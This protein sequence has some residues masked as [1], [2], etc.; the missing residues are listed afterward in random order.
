[1]RSNARRVDPSSSRPSTRSRLGTLLLL[2]GGLALSA[3]ISPAGCARDTPCQFNSDCVQA[4]CEAGECRKDC[5][6]SETDCPKGQ[7]CNIIAKCEADDPSGTT[8]SGGSSS[9]SSSSSGGGQGGAGSTTTGTTTSSSSSSSSSTSGSGGNDPGKGSLELCNGDQECAPNLVCRSL[10]RGGTKRCTPTCAGNGS[11]PSGTHCL[12]VDG[13]SY[14]AGVDTGRTCNDPSPCN[15]GC[16]LG[17]KYCTEPCFDGSD[18]PNGYGCMPVGGTPVCVKVEAPC[19]P[20]NAS[21]CIAPA[22]C[23]TTSPT[24]AVWGCTLACNT[25]A[26]CPRRAAGL[27]PWTC[28]GLCQRP[29]DVYGPL[30]GGDPA[31]YACNENGQPT[32]LCNDAQHINF[33]AF[34]IPPVPFVDCNSPTATPGQPGDSCVDSCRYQGGCRFGFA[35]VAVGGVGQSRIGLCLP[36][37]AGEIG[38][39]CTIDAQCTF[40]YCLNGSC[41]RDC[42]ADGLCPGAGSCVA[43]GGPAVEGAPFRRCQ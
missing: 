15:F 34:N 30:P 43:P 7:H 36:S 14:C 5:V 21:A 41:S 17:P 42:T 40:G 39:A 35:C 11:C 10:V 37:G 16:L 13:T 32:T 6:D 31:E 9:S 8:G 3:A 27:A 18:C 22:A 28:N 12:N 20:Q 23:D 25:A 19:T 29:P 4:Y 1:M 24:L 33:N 38:A 2:L 26:D